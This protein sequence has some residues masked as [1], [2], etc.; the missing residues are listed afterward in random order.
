MTTYLHG[1]NSLII[2]L[3]KSTNFTLISP[4]QALKLYGVAPFGGEV[5]QGG[6]DRLDNDGVAFGALETLQGKSLNTRYTLNTILE[7][8]AYARLNAFSPEANNKLL[9]EQVLTVANNAFSQFNLLLIYLARAKQSEL[10]NDILTQ[11]DI[12]KI[13]QE[14]DTTVQFFNLFLLIG[15]QINLKEIKRFNDEE[16]LK[17]FD[18]N[19]EFSFKNL[20]QK[21]NEKNLNLEMLAN[22]ENLTSEELQPVLELLGEFFTTSNETKI[23]P[24]YLEF[25]ERGRNTCSDNQFFYFSANKQ[26]GSFFRDILQGAVSQNYF[27]ELHIK[28]RDYLTTLEEKRELFANL[29]KLESKNLLTEEMQAFTDKPFPLILVVD[30]NENITDKF[31]IIE[32]AHAEYRTNNPLTFGQD[33][34]ILATD[35]EEHRLLIDTYFKCQNI[36]IQAITFNDLKVMKLAKASDQFSSFFL[37][38]YDNKFKETNSSGIL[39]LK[40]LLNASLPARQKLIQIVELARAKT[41]PGLKLWYSKSHFFGQGRHENV[42]KLYEEIAKI[43]TRL[44]YTS[45]ASEALQEIMEWIDKESFTHNKNPARILN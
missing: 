39:E 27:D 18:S 10:A 26:I 13:M 31:E 4:P 23:D 29:L 28:I 40:S 32:D 34:K 25:P 1:S 6:Y 21:I 41:A 45:E 2:P 36:A 22:Q 5:V 11:N 33:I 38:H 14:L 7:K 35:T 19:G 8:Y 37:S 3:L 20:C 30:D 17:L 42:H 24:Y 15:N 43:N 9:A 16:A 44:L 12:D